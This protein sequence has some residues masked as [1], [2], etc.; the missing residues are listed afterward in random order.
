MVKKVPL[1][2]SPFQ[3]KWRAILWAANDL[4]RNGKPTMMTTNGARSGHGAMMLF[5]PV[6]ICSENV[7]K[8]EKKRH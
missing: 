7:N 8:I 6:L 2:R 3:P 5:I 4:P 1:A